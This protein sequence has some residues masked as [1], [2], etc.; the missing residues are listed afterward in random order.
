MQLREL[1]EEQARL[2]SENQMFKQQMDILQERADEAAALKVE[3][4]FLLTKPRKGQAVIPYQGLPK[5]KV[6]AVI[7]CHLQCL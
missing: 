3:V 2:Q 6:L 5:R 7:C 1:L 4:P